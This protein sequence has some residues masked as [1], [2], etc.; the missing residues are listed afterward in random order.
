M[1]TKSAS[2]LEAKCAGCEP[3][4]RKTIELEKVLD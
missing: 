3:L 1:E 4:R 2:I